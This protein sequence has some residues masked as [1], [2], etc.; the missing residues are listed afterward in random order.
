MGM[1]AY[2]TG[3]PE[4]PMAMATCPITGMGSI[5]TIEILTPVPSQTNNQPLIGQ[6]TQTKT[7]NTMKT[8]QDDKCSDQTKKTDVIRMGREVSSKTASSCDSGTDAKCADK[9]AKEEIRENRASA[10]V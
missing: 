3:T 4:C 5:I 8:F 2:P 6:P 7:I 1:A 9:K 10:S